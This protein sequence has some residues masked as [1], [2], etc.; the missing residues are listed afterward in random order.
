M[1]DILPVA[2]ALTA[3]VQKPHPPQEETLQVEA[4][5]PPVHQDQA[6][7]Q[8]QPIFHLMQQ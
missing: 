2:T 4:A 8:K 7:P 3:A 5:D 6:G 1:P